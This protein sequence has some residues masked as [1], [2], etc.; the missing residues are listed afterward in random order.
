MNV[1]LI[2]PFAWTPK[3]TVSARTFPIARSL[4]KRGHEATILLVPYDNPAEA[5]R[6]FERE[7]VR[8]LELDPTCPG[9]ISFLRDPLRLARAALRLRPDVIHVFKPVGYSG[10]AGMW[11]AAL[12]RLPLVVDSDDWEGTGGWNDVNPYPR[13][14]K[15]FF[16]F[17]EHWLPRHAD[18]VT[19]ASR[20]LQTQVWGF[21]VPPARVIYLP[22][23]PDTLF[24]ERKAVGEER[25]EEIRAQL[26]VGDAALVIYVGHI[27]RGNDLDIAIEALPRVAA[28]VGDVRLVIV[29]EGD[30]RPALEERVRELGLDERITFTGLVDHADI[31]AY[32]AAA[33]VAIHPYRDTLINRAKCAAKVIGYMAMGKAVVTGRVGMNREYIVHGE[34]GL[35]TKPGDVGDFAAAMVRVLADRDLAA[36]L[37]HNAHARI[38]A[39]FDWDA[40]VGEIERAYAIARGRG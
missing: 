11:L 18:A 30:G 33:D 38:W 20:A 16:D 14:W 15:R 2:G 9:A 31:P 21:G 35:L 25:Q 10:L 8:V 34:S 6:E 39:E 32:L 4:V 12:S 24:R 36:E 3:G 40:R 26:G 37:G 7:G 5:G 28:E 27:P 19:V 23:G 13:V 22:N 17:Q 29:G 1:A